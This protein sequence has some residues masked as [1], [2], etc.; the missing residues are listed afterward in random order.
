[1]TNLEADPIPKM[2]HFPREIKENQIAKEKW[3]DIAAAVAIKRV[4]VIKRK[5]AKWTAEK[6]V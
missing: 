3:T 4:E 2:N 6:V 1:M 5:V